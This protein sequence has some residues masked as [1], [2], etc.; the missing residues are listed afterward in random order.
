MLLLLCIDHLLRSYAALLCA[1]LVFCTAT[2]ITEASIES[3]STSIHKIV[4]EVHSGK[5]QPTPNLDLTSCALL[6]AAFSFLPTGGK[7][8]EIKGAASEFTHTMSKNMFTRHHTYPL[9]WYFAS[10]LMTNPRSCTAILTDREGLVSPELNSTCSIVFRGKHLENLESSSAS[11][12]GDL[13]WK[14]RISRRRYVPGWTGD[15]LI[16]TREYFKFRAIIALC[17]KKSATCF[18]PRAPKAKTHY[19]RHFMAGAYSLY[20]SQV[21]RSLLV[22]ASVS[23]MEDKKHS[24]EMHQ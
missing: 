18:L 10:A 20:S 24:I 15:G 8:R 3:R 9:S 13:L 22:S 12:G 7:I 17:T 6:F 21:N 2:S 4:D 11:K 19:P 5:T 14:L 16:W 1:V 23:K